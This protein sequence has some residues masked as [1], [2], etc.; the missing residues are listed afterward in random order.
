M[1]T[2]KYVLSI[3]A[4]RYFGMI[5]ERT[6]SKRP[7]IAPWLEQCHCVEMGQSWFIFK[8][9]DDQSFALNCLVED[10]FD[11]L[12]DELADICGRKMMLILK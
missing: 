11:F 6:R 9:P 8:F 12:K 1:K 4:N 7:L 2:V 5:I 10:H 3:M